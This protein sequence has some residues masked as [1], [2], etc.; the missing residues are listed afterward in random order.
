MTV[1]QLVSSGNGSERLNKYTSN[2]MWCAHAIARM[3]A[4]EVNFDIREQIFHF[5]SLENVC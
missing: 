5:L 3:F 2:W 4:G 1:Y